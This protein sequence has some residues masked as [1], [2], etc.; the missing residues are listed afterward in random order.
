MGHGDSL[1]R[2][3]PTKI[4]TLE[5]SVKAVYCGCTYSA[6]ITMN[7]N[8]Y[9]WGR[10]TYGRLGHG[11]S[12]DK[13]LPT[14][15][16]ALREH[17]IIDVALGSGDSHTLCLTAE[18]LVFAWGD[19]DYGKLGNGS[20]NGA[21]LPQLIETLPLIKRVFAGSQFSMALSCDGKLYSWGKAYDGRLGHGLLDKNVQCLNT[22]KQLSALQVRCCVFPIVNSNITF[23]TLHLRSQRSLWMSRSAFGIVLL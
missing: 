14:H 10:G 1:L 6:A 15:V 4:Q 23:L 9:T 5:H 3:Q 16:Y 19:G 13:L 22:P 21:Q 20:C 11:N 18:G 2:E 8:L 17:S 12:D 7:G